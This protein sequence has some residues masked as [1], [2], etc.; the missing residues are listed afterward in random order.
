MYTEGEMRING[1]RMLADLHHIRTITDTPGA[2]VTRFSYGEK[3]G[4][5]RAYIKQV[6]E[7]AGFVVRTDAVGNVF[8]RPGNL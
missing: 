2:G 1:D 4:E 8:I 6:A 3:D 5:A 7:Q